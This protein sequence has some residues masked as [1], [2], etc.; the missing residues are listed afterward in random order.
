MRESRL[1]ALHLICGAG[2]LV[3]LG[4]HMGVMHYASILA[5]FGWIREPVM[6]FSAVA[7]RGRGTA[8]AA[9]Y[10][11]LLGF[12]LYHGLYGL[13]GVLGEI[14]GSP[15]AVRFINTGVVLFGL[16]V[17]VYGVAVAVQAARL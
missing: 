11:L 9:V 1:W 5:A 12:A 15:R 8:W 10:I 2:L 4:L 14:W 16:V 7:E 17:L 13:R 3:L 6:S